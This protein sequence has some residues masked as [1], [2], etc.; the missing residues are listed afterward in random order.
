MPFSTKDSGYELLSWNIKYSPLCVL[1]VTWFSLN[2][3]TI[4]KERL[5]VEFFPNGAEP[6]LIS[7]NLAN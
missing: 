6:L 3:A 4:K 7:V 1:C 5:T 2:G